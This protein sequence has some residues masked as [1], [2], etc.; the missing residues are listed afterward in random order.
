MWG[1]YDYADSV[2]E[3]GKDIIYM[4]NLDM[5]GHLPNN[6][7]AN[8]Y[9]GSEDAYAQLWAELAGP[10][11][12][13]QGVL[14]G[15]TASDHLP[16][17]DNGYDAIFVQE[18]W[19][20]SNYH[21]PSDSTTYI[22]FEYM[23]RMVK[24]SLATDYVVGLILPPVKF[25]G[26]YDVGDGQSLYLEWLPFDPATVD[27]YTI[28][29]GGY[30]NPPLA[31]VVVPGDSSHYTISGLTEGE[32]F[33]FYITPTNYLGETSLV[34]K[35]ISGTA[36][37]L[38]ASPRSLSALPLIGSVRLE[39]KA[40]NTEL[41]FSHY[42]IIRDQQ[43]LPDHIAGNIYIDDDPALGNDFHEYL[44]VAVDTDGNLSDTA[45]MTPVVAKAATLEKG[46]VLALNRTGS[47][48][49]AWV[50]ES[51]SGEVMRE[52][53]ADFNYEYM[54][55]TSSSSPD[56]AN[57]Y[58]LIDYE[59]I[60]V[61]A[62]G[63]RQDDILSS[64]LLDDICDYLSMGGK[65]VVF[66]RWGNIALIPDSFV[67]TTYT[68]DGYGGEYAQFFHLAG[69][70]L[71]LSFFQPTETMVHSDFVGA[72]SLMPEYPDLV[73][74][75]AMTIHHTGPYE[76]TGIPFPDFVLFNSAVPEIIYTYDS[77]T[78]DGRTEGNPVGWRHLGDDYKYVFFDI[79]FS[80]M[81]REAAV[82][83]LHQAVT[84]LG[85]IVSADDDGP[86]PVP[87]EFELLQNHPN[88]FNPQTEIEFFNP[89]ARSVHVSLEI[90]NI[91]GQRVKTLVDGDVAPGRHRVTWDGRDLNDRPAATGIY[92]YRLKTATFDAARKMLLLR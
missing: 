55:D 68:A 54:S 22:N 77:R 47:N 39:W 87:R 69:R 49:I 15:Q 43:L 1:S 13:I 66:G 63:G 80:F 90:F 67:T 71:P 11:V 36:H 19:F 6:N 59:V 79:P 92:F 31:T 33:V 88:P 8:L 28:N 40:E 82:A 64:D 20:S 34:S 35:S 23:T 32:L 2:A 89:E 12:G 57:L 61:S 86:A 26:I 76:C 7:D 41:D 3:I 56:R 4:Q 81:G 16:F 10:L 72:H 91:L 50:D 83:A 84:D 60:V 38:P 52:A 74:D 75:S 73:W 44:V 51:L 78:D 14:R 9:Y 17:L 42:Q 70:V 65:A 58:N 30:L 25:T 5:I 45:G 46:R 53:L 48:T 24:A 29:Y 21:Q 62:E 18:Y 37:I 85:L 27:F